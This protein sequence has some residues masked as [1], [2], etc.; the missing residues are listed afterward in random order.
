MSQSLP[1]GWADKPE[2]PVQH[3]FRLNEGARQDSR[4]RG[5]RRGTA[6]RYSLRNLPPIDPE[7]PEDFGDGGKR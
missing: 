5:G 7:N 2:T 6:T 4:S 3:T 1:P